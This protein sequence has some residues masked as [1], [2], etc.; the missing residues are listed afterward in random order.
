MHVDEMHR[1][2]VDL[3]AKNG[4]A[5]IW[6]AETDGVGGGQGSIDRF[7]GGGASQNANLERPAGGVFGLGASGESARDLLGAA[8][9]REA[10]ETHGV[11]IADQRGRLG[12][13]QDGE[14]KL[15]HVML[16]E[17]LICCGGISVGPA[18]ASGTD[19]ANS[20]AMIRSDAITGDSAPARTCAEA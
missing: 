18:D 1:A 5:L 13:S 2:V 10:S 7:A 12:G 16:R 9:S 14:G 3:L 8:R 11:A 20:A 17:E 6:R 15:T 4:I 19:P